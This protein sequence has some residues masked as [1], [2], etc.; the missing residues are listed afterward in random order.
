MALLLIYQPLANSYDDI[1]MNLTAI[2]KLTYIRDKA[3][4]FCCYSNFA[5]P[6]SDIIDYLYI[7]HVEETNLEDIDKPILKLDN[8]EFFHDILKDRYLPFVYGI[9]EKSPQKIYGIIT[10]KDTIQYLK[11]KGFTFDEIKDGKYKFSDLKNRDFVL[12]KQ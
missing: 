3:L 5:L 7:T 4:A 9:K 11:A 12:N 8:M 6:Q 2:R 10:I 1:N